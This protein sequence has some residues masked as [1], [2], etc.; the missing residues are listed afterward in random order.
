MLLMEGRKD[1]REVLCF[2]M[3]HA[4]PSHRPNNSLTLLCYLF[5]TLLLKEIK[6]RINR[7]TQPL[8]RMKRCGSGLFTTTTTTTTTVAETR[9][10]TNT[11]IYTYD[12]SSCRITD[13]ISLNLLS[14]G[15]SKSFCHE[16]RNVLLVMC[17]CAWSF[18]CSLFKITCV[19]Y[20]AYDEYRVYSR[21]VC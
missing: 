9:R 18:A 21:D 16:P 2:E 17:V 5:R 12:T 4:W 13:T 14:L 15:N 7:K 3:N 20:T 6:E 10:D 19:L 1:A 11:H 8:P